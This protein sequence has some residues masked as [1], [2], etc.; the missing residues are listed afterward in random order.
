[1]RIFLLSLLSFVVF[2]CAPSVYQYV[3]NWDQQ[4]G[5]NIYINLDHGIELTFPSER[6]IIYPK[7][8]NSFVASM[9]V[10]PAGNEPYHVLLAVKNQVEIMQLMIAPKPKLMDLNLEDFIEVQKATMDIVFGSQ[11]SMNYEYI[12]HKVI[13]RDGREIGMLKMNALG[14]KFLFT[15][16]M[17]NERFVIIAFNLV[18]AIFDA[19]EDEFWSIIDSYNGGL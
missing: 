3:G 17:E 13:E 18:E 2:S 7:P 1:M 14:Q 9:W 8:D 16:I 5:T 15:T 12:D 6:W 10:R 19:R 4:E 11:E